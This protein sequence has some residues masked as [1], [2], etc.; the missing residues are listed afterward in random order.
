MTA[1]MI[2]GLWLRSSLSQTS[3]IEFKQAEQLCKTFIA[4]QC[5]LG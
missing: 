4:T 3:D 5:Q 1:A 2:D